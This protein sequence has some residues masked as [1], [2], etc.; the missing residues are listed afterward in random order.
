MTSLFFMPPNEIRGHQVFVLSVC[1]C[2][3][4]SKKTLTLTLT[5][6]QQEIETLYLAYILN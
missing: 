4:D 1:V 3:S 2:V 6:K 5:F